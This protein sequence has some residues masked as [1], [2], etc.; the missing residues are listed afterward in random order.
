[1]KVRFLFSTIFGLA[2]LAMPVVP[3]NAQLTDQVA[4]EQAGNTVRSQLHLKPDQFFA[5]QRDEELEQS[6]A[7]TIGRKG[8]SAFIYEVSPAGYEVKENT[9]VYHFWTDFDGV[10]IIAIGPE[11]GDVYRIHGFADSLAEF[12]KLLTASRVRV[13]S[14]DQ[15]EF[16]ADFYR[17]VNP[18]NLSLT[19]VSSLVELK[20]AAERQC[21]TSSFEQSEKA[22][23]AWWRHAKQL[24]AD[25]VFRQT[26]AP[27]G[28]AYFVEWIVLSSRS[29]HSC[30]GV[31]LRT[32]L[33]VTSDGHAS[34]VTFSPVKNQ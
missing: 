12:E 17:Q 16:L 20:Q 29:S 14:S 34:K 33:E 22:F 26:V 7:V 25:V 2:A 28:T 30:G 3:A 1:M 18:E 4:R 13:S 23:D 32:R 21:Q 24:Y 27:N 31:P 10:F 5:V 19:R 11:G 8:D 9:V 15:A 6:L